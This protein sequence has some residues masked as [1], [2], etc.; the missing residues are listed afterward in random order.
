M[1]R[2][3]PVLLVCLLAGCAGGGPTSPSA[4][5]PGYQVYGRIID[6]AARLP[7]HNVT[8]SFADGP[9]V[10]KMATTSA[11]GLYTLDNVTAGTFTLRAVQ[12]G[13]EE[14]LQSVTITNR[15]NIDIRMT[16]QRAVNSGWSGGQF[17]AQSGKDQISARLTTVQVARTGTNLEG[18]FTTADGG[19]GTFGGV[20]LGTTFTGWMRVEVMVGTPSRRCH[21]SSGDVGGSATPSAITLS[22]PGLA[23]EDCA[24]PITNVVLTITP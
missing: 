16:P 10:G 7:L 17:L 9:N 4:A 14:F 18:S 5:A 12:N 23:L 22:T 1:Q 24:G 2:L 15:T 13:Y 6:A 20:V 21:G 8:V 19:S 3:S 11:E